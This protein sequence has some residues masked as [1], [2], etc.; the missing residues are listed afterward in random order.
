MNE[1]PLM[2]TKSSSEPKTKSS[3]NLSSLPLMPKKKE[4]TALSGQESFTAGSSEQGGNPRQLFGM[5]YADWGKKYGNVGELVADIVDVP[6]YLKN[7]IYKNWFSGG[8][9]DEFTRAD[10]AGEAPDYDKIAQFRKNINSVSLPRA[11]QEKLDATDDPVTKVVKTISEVALG[12]FA[13]S[14]GA[15]TSKTGAVGLGTG[16]LAGAGIGNVF[17]E[18]TAPIGAIAGW[19]AASSYSNEFGGAI[20]SAMED[21]GYDMTDPNSIK[22]AYNDKSLMDDAKQKGMARGIPI[23]AIDLFTAGL[24]SKL[25]KVGLK[26]AEKTI[27]KEAEVFTEQA[28]K[29]IVGGIVT[30]AEGAAG[31]IGEATGQLVSEGKISDWDAVKMEFLGE[32]G[33]GAPTIAYNYLKAAQINNRIN[34]VNSEKIQS[35]QTMYESLP[36]GDETAPII[37]EK[38]DALKKDNLERNSMVVEALDTAPIPVTKRVLELTNQIESFDQRLQE[39]GD[40]SKV[41]SGLTDEQRQQQKAFQ[42]IHTELTTERDNIVGELAKAKQFEANTNAT[43]PEQTM[44]NPIEVTKIQKAINSMTEFVGENLKAFAPTFAILPNGDYS[45]SIGKEGK[46]NPEST[47]IFNKEERQQRRELDSMLDE[48]KVTPEEHINKVTELNKQ[49]IARGIE[50][51]TQ[52]ITPKEITPAEQVAKEQVNRQQELE[53]ALAQPENDKGTVTVGKS[54]IDRKEVQAEL[55]RIKE[56]NKQSTETAP[57]TEQVVYETKLEDKKQWKGD[58]EIID[59]RQGQAEPQAPAQ[60]QSQETIDAIAEIEQRRKKELK[61]LGNKQLGPVGRT[62]PTNEIKRDKIN[63]KYDAELKA[64]ENKT[65]SNLP[66][67]KPA[68]RWIVKNN[69]TGK[70]LSAMTKSEAIDMVNNAHEHDFGQGTTVT[71]TIAVTPTSEQITSNQESPTGQSPDSDY[72]YTMDEMFDDP[73]KMLDHFNDR[74]S[75]EST[76]KQMGFLL[77]GYRNI[78]EAI[79]DNIITRSLAKAIGAGFVGIRKVGKYSFVKINLKDKDGNMIAHDVSLNKVWS[80]AVGYLPD[81]IS[82]LMVKAHNSNNVFFKEVQHGFGNVV[83][84]LTASENFQ[85]AR[86]KLFGSKN[87]ATQQITKLGVQLNGMIG[88]DTKALYRVHSLLDPEAFAKEPKEGRPNSI[89]DLSFSELRLFNALRQMNDFVHEWHYRNGFLD[90]NTYQKNKGKYFARAYQQIENKQFADIDE[91]IN[92][93]GAGAE[94]NMFR[95]RKDFNEIENLTLSDPIYITI[96]RFGQMLGNKAIFDFAQSVANDRN[97]KSYSKLSDVPENN[98]QY[99]KK[100]NGNGNPKRFGDLT[101]KYVPIEIYEQLYGTQ[102]VNKTISQINDFATKYDNMFFR[103]LTKKLKTVAS[104]LTRGANIISGYGFAMLGGVDPINLLIKKASARKSLDSYDSWAQELTKAG[105][106]GGQLSGLDIKKA[107]KE[108]QGL[109]IIKSIL[110]DKAAKTYETTDQLISDTYGKTDDLTKLAYY[111]TLVEEYGISKEQAIKDTAKHMQNYNTVTNGFKLFAKLPVVGNAFIKFKPD[112]AR[113]LFNVFK[114]KPMFGLM[115]LATMTGLS[116]MFS[117]LSGESEE[118][119]KAREKRPNT[120]KLE[121]GDLLSVSFGWKIGNSEYNVGRYISPYTM[122]DKGYKGSTLS[123]MSEFGPLQVMYL[124]KGTGQG[125]FGYKLKLQDPLLGPVVQALFNEDNNGLNIEDPRAGKYHSET[126]S[127]EQK[128]YNRLMY[129]GRSWGTPYASWVTNILDATSE[130]ANYKGQI[131]DP[132]NAMLSIIVKNEKIDKDILIEKYSK[133]FNNIQRDIDQIESNWISKH[134]ESSL[135]KQRINMQFKN[136]DIKS[137]ENRDKQ[138]QDIEDEYSNTIID[139]NND[140]TDKR[141]EQK[142]PF[143]MAK[144]LIKLKNKTNPK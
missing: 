133:E 62:K 93:A 104:P 90:E 25:G 119:R 13:Q 102:F 45:L 127:G 139:W 89:K 67:A 15:G 79:A 27:L 76:A 64:L 70:S 47:V 53:T 80:E 24:S 58:F 21:K 138:I 61:P 37:K 101:N 144:D 48:G 78:S 75:E 85:E 17:A 7:V 142:F 81:Q 19:Q 35:L 5:S 33:S 140:L 108:S 3:D 136:G 73:S 54:L 98:Q 59:N 121:L 135:A 4:N 11:V 32:I 103:Q 123:D 68:G 31:S 95:K 57:K 51:K 124:G 129:I 111:R 116:K 66:K 143:D 9:N 130:K 2:P 1:L 110:G 56:A 52:T 41:G 46:P 106:L 12:S 88:N 72:K 126:V 128:L 20:A 107:G 18:V 10:R 105:L 42:D 6:I 22:K 96:K 113:I 122:Y 131:N 26:L 87:D 74:L 132:L 71:K 82:A 63:A 100:L 120:T 60:E 28:T 77:K 55:D 49:I 137:I 84:N 118:E 83:T 16:A 141:L 114:D 109:G 34:N 115:F 125:V 14:A 36:E 117:N 23:A 134:K 44:P 30:V 99:Y 97:Y 39:F 94:F 50:E 38:I 112:S 69:V 86:R 43:S 40:A 91:A 92:K 8:I 29:K 65:K